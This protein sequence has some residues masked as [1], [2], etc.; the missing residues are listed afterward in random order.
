MKLEVLDKESLAIKLESQSLNSS[1]LRTL[2][3]CIDC[4]SP[5]NC[6]FVVCKSRKPPGP[7]NSA[8][9][10]ARKNVTKLLYNGNVRLMSAAGNRPS[11]LQW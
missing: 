5:K 7:T 3:S 6:V 11:G 2:Y 8:P 10:V 9:R 4:E 1:E